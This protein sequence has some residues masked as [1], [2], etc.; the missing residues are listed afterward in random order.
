MRLVEC[1]AWQACLCLLVVSFIWC[2]V[3]LYAK[4]LPACM[5]IYEKSGKRVHVLVPDEVEYRRAFKMWVSGRRTHYHQFGRWAASRREGM[6][7]HVVGAVAGMLSVW[8]LPDQLTLQG[9]F[10]SLAVTVQH[11]ARREAHKW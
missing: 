7:I 11:V 1:L 2:T 5:Q 4:C 9:L 6:P 3:V 10:H 8:L